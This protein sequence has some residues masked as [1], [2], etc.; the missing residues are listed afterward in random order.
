MD[1]R[2]VSAAAAPS[3]PPR[4][5]ALRV[6]LAVAVTGALVAL[7]VWAVPFREVLVA[8]PA[9]ARR[10]M[11]ASDCAASLELAAD[12]LL[13]VALRLRDFALGRVAAA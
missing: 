9:D 3:A 12:H 5:R 10:I 1:E 7:I 4:R 2:P 6:A 13:H 8:S 11:V